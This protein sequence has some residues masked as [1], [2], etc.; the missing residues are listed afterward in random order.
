MTRFQKVIFLTLNQYF[1]LTSELTEF[2]ESPS[3]YQSQVW[4]FQN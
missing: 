2:Q 3:F 4:N 1:G